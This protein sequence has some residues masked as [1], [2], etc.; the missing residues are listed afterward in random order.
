MLKGIQL[1]LMAG[2]GV[3]VPVSRSVIDALLDV[4][5]TVSTN[6]VSAFQLKF[7]LSQRSPLHSI[8]LLAGGSLPKIFRVALI[9]T[10]NGT[11]QTIINGVVTDHQIS[12][13]SGRDD[14][15]L[16]VTGEDLTRIMDYIDFTG[17][18]YPAMPPE[19][20]VAVIVAKY[21]ALGLIPKIVPTIARD[22]DSPLDRVAHHKGT[23]LCYLKLL[24]HESGHIFYLE[25]GDAP[26]T[27]NA[28][29]GPELQRGVPQPA[30]SL[31]MGVQSNVDALNF[32]FDNSKG[33]QPIVTIHEPITKLAIPIPVPNISP[34]SPSLGVIPLTRNRVKQSDDAAHLT[35]TKALL[36]G[37]AQATHTNRGLRAT[38]IL[39]VLR[40][41]GILKPHRLV[42]VRG[43]G[44]AFNGLYHVDSV[45]HR[46]SQGQYK[47]DFVL[48]RNALV[49]NVPRVVA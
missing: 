35:P 9:A 25:P 40:Y 33:V 16:T 26:L 24:A 11:A 41:G 37:A 7:L 44:I 19:A 47:Q 3:P 43:A 29:W 20:R 39:D 2:P 14:A 31:N 45:T 46:I 18:P 34:L 36:R 42:G 5:V 21:A 17:T 4:E 1:T 49:S 38:G 12:P 13:G 48:S 27:T 15:T 30:L 28:Y 23:D 6:S 8:F 22:F 10:L 32:Q